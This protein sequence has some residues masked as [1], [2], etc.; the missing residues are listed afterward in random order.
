MDTR[1]L[2][3]KYVTSAGLPSRKSSTPGR[4]VTGS[5]WSATSAM[6][7]GGK[8]ARNAWPERRWRAASLT[9]RPPR[10]APSV[11]RMAAAS[12]VMSMPTGHQAMHRPQPT[13]PDVSNWS[14]QVDS[15]WVSH[16]R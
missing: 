10:R 3:M 5:A 1:P 8:P 15:L 12:S 7:S 13:Q 16:C 2:V 14:H 6:A 9:G 11:A 4:N